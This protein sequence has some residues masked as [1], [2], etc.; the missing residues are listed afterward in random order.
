MFHGIVNVFKKRIILSN[1][2]NLQKVIRLPKRHIAPL[3]YDDSTVNENLCIPN[4]SL[5]IA[6]LW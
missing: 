3:S 1:Y 4:V 6:K 5:Y 2:I